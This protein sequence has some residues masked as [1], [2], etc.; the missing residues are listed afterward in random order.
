MEFGITMETPQLL[1]WLSA[2]LEGSALIE[3]LCRCTSIIF[4]FEYVLGCLVGIKY[5]L[6]HVIKLQIQ[7]DF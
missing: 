5:I 4:D 6:K 2:T 7:I 3:G 1:P